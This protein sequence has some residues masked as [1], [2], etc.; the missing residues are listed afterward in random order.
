MTL[1]FADAPQD[2]AAC[3]A[4]D[5]VHKGALGKDC[6]T[7]HTPNGWKLWDFDHA[8]RTRFPLTGAHAKA[9]CPQCHLR[10]ENVSKPSMVCGSCHT[11]DDVH[12]GRFGQQCQECHSTSS[13]KRPRAN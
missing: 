4:K 10:P 6:A 2:C 1:Q 9:A 12:A 5:D 11:E 13:F 7:C 8:A 3:H